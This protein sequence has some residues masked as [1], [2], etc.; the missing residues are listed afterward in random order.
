MWRE[1]GWREEVERR[2]EMER[3][4]ANP[5]STFSQT[6]PSLNRTT[7]SFSSTQL[8]ASP[9][10]SPVFITVKIISLVPEP[11]QEGYRV[12]DTRV[13]PPPQLKFSDV[14]PDPKEP[15]P[16]PTEPTKM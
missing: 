12:S 8:S 9:S 14:D 4:P 1:S 5:C 11:Y 16:G 15:I 13:R 3:R 6:I 7:S 2:G 10:T